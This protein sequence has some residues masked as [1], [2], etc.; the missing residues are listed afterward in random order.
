MTQ[1]YEGS[2]AYQETRLRFKSNFDKLE[3]Q[4]LNKVPDGSLK[5]K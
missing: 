3:K 2:Q 4:S 1:S 5:H